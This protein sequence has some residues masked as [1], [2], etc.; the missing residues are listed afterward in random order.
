MFARS[1]AQTVLDRS[2]IGLMVSNTTR[3]MDVC[4]P[5]SLVLLSFI[6]RG[7]TMGRSPSKESYQPPET[8]VILE[9]I[10]N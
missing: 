4:S 3:G 5:S 8:F 1:E 2:N 6:G 9:V 10:L 7:F